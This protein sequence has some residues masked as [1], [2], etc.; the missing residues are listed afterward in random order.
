[1]VSPEERRAEIRRARAASAIKAEYQHA[2]DQLGE[3]EQLRS[4]GR[5]DIAWRG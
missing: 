5:P 3:V 4:R 2:L 1:M